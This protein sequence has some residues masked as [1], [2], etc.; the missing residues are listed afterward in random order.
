MGI[1]PI[2]AI[3]K[4]LAQAG[5]QHGD[6]DWIELNEA[7]A[8]Q[9]LAVVKE[10]GLDPSKINPLGGADRPR[11][12]ARRDRRHPHGNH[13]AWHAAPAASTAWSRCASAPAW[14][15]PVSSSV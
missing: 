3:P 6:L 5:I 2:A 15:P 4:A 12:P 7:F 9:S 10:L 1:G 11:P 13:R 14:V 8:A